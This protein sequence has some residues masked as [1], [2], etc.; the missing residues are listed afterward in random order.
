MLI[1]VRGQ[2]ER[3]MRPPERRAQPRP[4]RSSSEKLARLRAVSRS[5]DRGYRFVA[6]PGFAVASYIIGVRAVAAPWRGCSFQEPV[7][8]WGHFRTDCSGRRPL[9]NPNTPVLARRNPNLFQQ[10]VLFG[11]PYIAPRI[12]LVLYSFI[13]TGMRVSLNGW[14]SGIDMKQVLCEMTCS[15]YCLM[16]PGND[17]FPTCAR[18]NCLWARKCM[19]PTRMSSSSSFRSTA[20]S[21]CF[22]S[23]SMATRPRFRSWAAKALSAS[24]C[25][26][27]EKAH[28]A[29]AVIQSAGTAYRLPA[30]ELKREFNRDGAFRALMLRYTQ[31]LITQMAQTAVCNRHHSI[32][33]QLAR[34]LLLSLDRLPSNQLTMTQEL[35]AN[36][37]GVR[38]EGVTEAAGKLQ[39]LGVI[40]YQ[41]GRITVLDRPKLEELSCECYAVVKEESDRLAAYAKKI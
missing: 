9:T 14:V 19:P 5:I 18:S 6:T 29:R 40:N 4:G 1:Y 13:L 24:R 23:C 25:S 22:T 32:D 26:W 37:L 30:S 20:S 15:L 21:R 36:M 35:I 28:Q 11:Y 27:A 41:R 31:A 33:Q 38:R 12:W 3:Q 7:N 8:I 16:R 39:K 2:V 10:P 34:W 17:S